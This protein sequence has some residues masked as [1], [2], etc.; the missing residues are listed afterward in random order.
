MQHNLKLK[1]GEDTEG[2]GWI[3]MQSDVQYVQPANVNVSFRYMELK[4]KCLS[5]IKKASFF[6]FMT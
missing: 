2:G 3:T 1:L 4:R 5:R 6:N